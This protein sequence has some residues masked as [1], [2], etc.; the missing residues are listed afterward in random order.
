MNYC[1]LCENFFE[2]YENTNDIEKSIR[3][4]INNNYNLLNDIYFFQK[5]CSNNVLKAIKIKT[6][7]PKISALF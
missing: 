7:P 5:R 1:I 2:E 4:Y 6:M 3:N